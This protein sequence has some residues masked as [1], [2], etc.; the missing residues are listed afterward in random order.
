MGGT[1]F[2]LWVVS[3]HTLATWNRV[4]N[5]RACE[6]AKTPTNYTFLWSNIT[7]EHD[8]SD[9]SLW[10]SWIFTRPHSLDTEVLNNQLEVDVWY[11]LGDIEWYEPI[12]MT[13]SLGT[14]DQ[15]GDGLVNNGRQH[16]W[17]LW[18]G[19]LRRAVR[20]FLKMFNMCEEIFFCQSFVKT[21]SV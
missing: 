7:I 13:I 16:V 6:G 21:L 3:V 10:L 20:I 19:S 2:L 17:P 1:L 14:W 12:E 4:D 11:K 5:N 8:P 15:R 18:R 9:K